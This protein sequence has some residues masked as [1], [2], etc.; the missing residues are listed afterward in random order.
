MS[1][2]QFVP[3]WAKGIIWYQIFPERFRNGDPNN[4]PNAAALEGAW[5]HDH[6]SPWQVHP[7]TADWYERQPYEQR[8]GRDIWFNIQR[9]RYGGDLQG[10]IDSLDYLVD[11]GIEA[12]YLNP[13]FDAPS[14]HKYDGVTYHHIAPHF[15]PD[16]DGDRRLIDGETPHDPA[17]WLWTA[18]DR[19]ALRL[20]AEV[21]RR[22]LRIIF[23]GVWNHMG[24]NS[25]A[26]RDVVARQRESAYHDWF[27]INSWDDP[28]AGTKFDYTGWAGARELPE[29]AQNE[30][31]HLAGPRDYIYAATRRWMDPDGDGDPADGI[32]GW[33]LDVAFCIRHPFWKAWRQH[34]RDINPEAYLVA[35]VVQSPAAEKPYLEGDEFDAVMNYNFLFAVFEF[36][37]AGH[38]RITATEFDAKLRDLRE[39]HPA[40]VAH[41]MQNLVDGHD[42]S[43]LASQIV[44]RDIW[45]IRDWPEFFRRTK[46]AE[47]PDYDTRRP[48]AAERR[49]QHLVALFQMTYIGAP[50]IYYGDE[51]GLWGANDPCCRKPMIWPDR[52]Y[53]P[54]ATLPTGATRP[55]TDE[56]AFDYEL[57]AYY[58]RIIAL[59]KES[60]A[61]RRGD[62][63]TLLADDARHLFAFARETA[64][65]AAVVVFNADVLPHTVELP[66]SDGHWVDALSGELVD[67]VDGLGN[68][69][70]APVSGLVLRRLRH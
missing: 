70:L 19:L 14:A 59:R 6:T 18:A 15:G 69:S 36:F 50:M 65:D 25:F 9:R 2:D 3:E 7:W 35:E 37:I 60:P 47:A 17:S 55:Q 21:H 31:G 23:D 67:L 4:D 28:A 46:A 38:Y 41:V 10:I 33:R 48:T 27:K 54:E 12:I 62:Y 8:N 39:M 45:S 63:R 52:N 64:D 5:P 22:G 26:F 51:A 1:N 20:I 49:V 44:N 13:I 66:L 53:A 58:R 30:N 61:L 42:T 29:M 57:H 43:R 56:V 40:E 16:P 32:D 34:V 11:L 24:V 68:T